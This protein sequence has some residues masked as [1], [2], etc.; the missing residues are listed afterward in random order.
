M[1]GGEVP[2]SEDA[3]IPLDVAEPRPPFPGSLL[4]TDDEVIARSMLGRR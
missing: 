4:E 2:D 1:F 3:E